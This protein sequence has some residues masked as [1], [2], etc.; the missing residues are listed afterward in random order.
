MQIKSKRTII[1]I[2]FLLVLVLLNGAIYFYLVKS[3]PAQ[4]QIEKQPKELSHGPCL[5]DDEEVMYSYPEE[6]LLI[7]PLTIT[8]KDK[9]TGEKKLS[10]RIENFNHEYRH[11]SRIHKC[12][13]YFIKMI[14]YDPK[15][16]KQDP[17]FKEEL[18]R[19][20]YDKVCEKIITL[21]E[22][23]E[24]GIYHSFYNSFFSIDLVERYLILTQG[25]LGS[26][27]YALVIKNLET[28]EDVFV[29]TLKEITNEYPH[30]M[31]VFSFSHISSL[32]EWIKNGK[33]FWGE[34]ADQANVLAFFRIERDTWKYEIFEAP[35]GTMGGDDLNTELGYV[36]Y[37]DGPPWTG[38]LEFAKM[39]QEQWEREGKIVS[40]YLYNLFTK[41]KTLL[42]TTTD[43][44]WYFKP[45]WLSDTELQ[46]EL[47]GDEKKIYKINEK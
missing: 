18:W 38:D 9:N 6:S 36:T 28:N 45:K 17:G 2:A 42:A 3:F 29:L 44:M 43:T 32:G 24:S 10:F 1:L 12:G 15:K 39:Y 20:K 37:D 16:T 35:E 25:Y 13:F 4:E 19:C 5:A 27:D 14:N 21:A 11:L 8:I 40:F 33:Y 22:K 23:D 47:P 30:F 26:P 41:E 31:G 46:Y 7:V 34:I